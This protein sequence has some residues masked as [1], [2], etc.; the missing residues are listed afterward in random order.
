MNISLL[1]G[2]RFNLV[3]NRK[4]LV[5]YYER[6]VDLLDIQ[7]GG[8]ATVGYVEEDGR[9]IATEINLLA[10]SSSYRP[11]G[12]SEDQ[13]NPPGEGKFNFYALRLKASE[14]A[15]SPPLTQVRSGETMVLT[16]SVLYQNSAAATAH[17]KISIA[18]IGKQPMHFELTKSVMPP[19]MD[20]FTGVTVENV[21]LESPAGVE[22]DQ[23]IEITGTVTA[24]GVS[25][26]RSLRFWVLPSQAQR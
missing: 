26:T 4:T 21:T 2:T 16:F 8:K 6:P 5:R 20:R 18:P 1:R 15:T 3:V 13:P 11:A 14:G 12:I 17:Y 9:F 19:K 25:Q 23:A 24:N 22:T 7:A 10:G